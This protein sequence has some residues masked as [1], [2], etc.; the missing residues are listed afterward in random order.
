MKNIAALSICC[1]TLLLCPVY[2]AGANKASSF[3]IDTSKPYVYLEFDHVARRKPLSQ[4]ENSEGLW[5]RIVNNCR[6]PIIV[7]TFNPGTGDP[8]V[9]IYDE[10]IPTLVKGPYFEGGRAGKKPPSPPPA[11]RHT[12]P[13]GYTAEVFSTTMIEPGNNLLFSVPL[14]HVS[15]SWY[16]QILFN[17]D[18]AGAT[19]GSEPE[20]SVSF[21]WQDIP[22]RIRVNLH[23]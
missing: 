21:H 12:P 15:Q 18:V 8:G 17:L 16:L 14:S 19:Y 6:V 3:V 9:G 13:E 10:V 20:S 22:E 23:H 4:T 2:M 5:L 1:L 11:I 7:A